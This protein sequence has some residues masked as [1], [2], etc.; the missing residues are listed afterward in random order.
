MFSLNLK[1]LLT[2]DKKVYIISFTQIGF[3]LLNIILSIICVK[4]YPSIHVLKLCNGFLYIIQPLIY[5]FY[6]KKYFKI[7]KHAKVDNNLLKNRWSGFA[8]NFAAFV[9]LST[10]V[11]I[12][13]LFTNLATVSIY[14]V[15]SIVTNGL[16]QLISSISNGV[17]PTIGQLYASGNKE[18]LIKKFN[19]YEFALTMII[20][21]IF[22]VTSL[23]ITPFVLIYTKNIT[24][25]NYYQPVF[26]V[27]LALSEAVYLLKAPHTSLAYSAKKFKEITP[28]CFIE[29]IVNIILSVI[30]VPK[31][32]LLGVAIGTLVAMLI[33]GAYQVDYSNILLYGKRNYNFLIK[34]IILLIPTII[35]A[36]LLVTLIPIGKLT[37]FNWVIKA[38]IYSAIYA[39]M[40]L[41]ITLIFFKKEFSIVMEYFRRR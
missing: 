31:I 33:R 22:A 21:F 19:A 41:I 8:I 23:L 36:V 18:E 32:G 13:T 5:G 40:Y 12:L 20:Y 11:T 10:D 7:D 34:N 16:K 4:I 24:D 37:L 27:V 35:L 9:H 28:I 15:Y 14:S 25:T 6:V 26:G 1:T 30:L 3:I 29:A 2:A 17:S 38:I 39:I